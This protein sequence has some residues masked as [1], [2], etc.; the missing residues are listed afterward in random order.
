MSAGPIVTVRDLSVGWPGERPLLE[1]A[2]FAVLEGE[3]FA[4]L[5]GS[6]SGKSTL[7]RVLV[8]LEEP[9][10]GSVEIAGIG[11]PTLEAERPRFGV[12]FQQGALFGSMKVGENVA[13]PIK[14]WT[15][16]PPDAINAIVRAKLRLVGL[17]AAENKLPSELSGGMKKRAAIARAMALEPSL[18]FLDEPSSGLDPVTSSELD[19]LILTLKHVLGLTVVL[20]THELRSILTI[21][22]RCVML[23][24]ASRSIIASGT[25]EELRASADPRVSGFFLRTPEAA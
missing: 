22:D 8:G 12:M 25:P 17:E 3:V 16:L 24:A 11:R 2:T 9:V 18:L 13:L 21:V 5:G 15:D 10:A 14:R 19:R 20:V 23:D 7:M 6:G 4:V 1:H